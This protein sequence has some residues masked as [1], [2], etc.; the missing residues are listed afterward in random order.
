M[1]RYW[2]HNEGVEAM[3]YEGDGAALSQWL[4]NLNAHATVISADGTGFELEVWDMDPSNT[5][6][7]TGS[8]GDWIAY[9]YY[10]QA[11]TD[12]EFRKRFQAAD[13]YA[14]TAALAALEARVSALEAQ[15]S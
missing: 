12:A 6:P 8:T 13:T 14:T 7:V 10:P 2:F 11:Y 3:A 9:V 4:S 1:S 15:G 5:F